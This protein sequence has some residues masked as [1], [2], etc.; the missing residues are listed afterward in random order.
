MSNHNDV[1]N[2]SYSFQKSNIYQNI[3]KIKNFNFVIKFPITFLPTL[4]LFLYQSNFDLFIYCNLK[5]SFH[6]KTR[7]W[8]IFFSNLKKVLGTQSGFVNISIKWSLFDFIIWF[9]LYGYSPTSRIEHASS[10]IG[11]DL[12]NALDLAER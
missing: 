4:K 1:T 10:Y 5:C 12:I 11:W 9:D 2:H 3:C 8:L 7:N 6:W